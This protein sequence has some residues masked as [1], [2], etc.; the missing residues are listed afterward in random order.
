[1]AVVFAFFCKIDRVSA[2]VYRRVCLCAY[3]QRFNGNGADLRDV[4]NGDADGVEHHR[5]PCGVRQGHFGRGGYGVDYAYT[6]G[7]NDSFDVYAF[8]KRCLI[9]TNND[10]KRGCQNR[11][12]LYKEYPALDAGFRKC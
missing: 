2:V 10:K 11:V 12:F 6:L 5:Y 9:E 8:A 7:G 3:G 1:M 4:R